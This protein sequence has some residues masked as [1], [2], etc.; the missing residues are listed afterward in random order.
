[1]SASSVS[2]TLDANATEEIKLNGNTVYS[3]A[4]AG[5]IQFS[6]TG[7]AAVLAVNLS[8]GFSVP[9]NLGYAMSA[10]FELELNTYSTPITISGITLPADQGSIQATGDLRFLG[11]VVD[12]HGTFGITVSSSSLSVNVAANVTFLGATFTADGFAGIY[13]DSNPG[14]ALKIDLALPGGAQG[15]APISALGNN[16]VISGAFELEL[17][18]CSVARQN[19]AP[20]HS[21]Y[22]DSGFQVAVNNLGVYLYGFNLTGS[23]DISITTAG[24]GFDANLNLNLFGFA[25]IGISGYYHPDQ[26]FSFTGT[27]GFQFGDHTFGFGG[28]V[29][30]TVAS[31]GFDASV[32]GWAAAF[33]L[34]IS[35]SGSI[36]ITGTSV[37]ISAAFSVTIVPAINIDTPDVHLGFLGTIHG[38]HIHTAA[39]VITE[40]ATYHLGS[41]SPPPIVAQAAP[42]PPTPPPVAGI[43]T[44]H[45]HQNANALELYI[46]QDVGNRV[47]GAGNPTGPQTAENYSISRVPGDPNSNNGETVTVSALGYIQTFTNVQ[48]ILVNNTLTGNDTINVAS[49]IQVP[50]YMSLGSGNNTVNTGGGSATVSVNGNGS[51][52]ITT[53]SG[54]TITV[55][56]GGGG[57]NQISAGAHA[58]VTISGNGKNTVTLSDGAGGSDAASVTINGTGQNTINVNDGTPTISIA[59]SASG[60]NTIQVDTASVS[61][62]NVHGSGGNTIADIGSGAATITVD[63]NGANQITGGGT[64]GGT[65][66]NIY[67]TGSGNNNI[68]TGSGFA[69]IYDQGI[70][71]NTVSGGSGGGTDYYG[72][73]GNGVVYA[74][75]GGSSLSTTY[76]NFNVVVNGYSTY[77]LSNYGLA[78]GGYSLG[79][80]GVRNVT[81]NAFSAATA[82]SFTLAN[83]TGNA[84]L[85]GLGSNNSLT[86]V[87]GSTASGTTDLLTNTSLQVTGG[88]TQTITLADFQTANLVGSMNGASSFDLTSWTGNGS[89]TGQSNSNTLLATNDVASF[90]LSDTLFQRSGHGDMTLSQVQTANLNGGGSANTFTVGSWSGTANLDGKNGSDAYNLTLSG[91][92]TGT[93]NVSDSGSSGIDTL[94]I[95]AQKT[96]LVTSTSVR[97]GTQRVN[98]G[99]SGIEVLN[100]LGGK[101]SLIFNDQST[102]ANLTT[103]VQTTGNSN[104]INIGST[105]GMAPLSPGVVNQILGLLNLVGSGLDTANVDDT[106]DG[107]GQTGYLTSTHLT[108]LA[109]GAQGIT[110]SGLASLNINLGTGADTFDVQATATGTATTVN[111][112]TGNNTLNVSS[113]APTNTGNLA[114][115]KSLLT[116]IGGGVSTA[117]ISDASDASNSSF[118]LTGTTLTSSLNGFGSGGS[119]LYGSLAKVNLQ[120]GSKQNSITVAGNGATV[121]T[122]ISTNNTLIGSDTVNVSSTTNPLV[123]NDATPN[124]TNNVQAIGTVVTINGK[125]GG[126]DV[127]NVS[128]NAPTNTGNLAGIKALLTINGGGSSTANISDGSD[129]SNSSFN[130]TGTTL[131]SSL[132]GFGSGGSVLYGSLANLNIQLGSIQNAITVTGNGATVLT[133]INT[134]STS[135][136]SDTVNVSSTTNPLVVNDT[137]T[138][139]INNVQS[140]NAVVTINGKSGGADVIS[141]SSNAP[142]N[143]G[144][145]AGIKAVLTI[146]GGGGTSTANVSDTGDS[147][148]TNSVLSNSAFISTAFGSGG[149]IN[150]GTLANLNIKLGS[151]GNQFTIT[152][153]AFATTTFVNTGSGADTVN[154]NATT[155]P[156]TVNTGGGANTNIVN[157]GSKQPLTNGIVDGIQGSLTIVGDGVDTMNVD[158]TGSSIAK[159]GTLTATTLTGLNMGVGGI[160]YSGLSL[161]NLS[162]GSGGSSGNALHINVLSGQNLPAIANLNGGSGGRDILAANWVTD[163]NNT[164]NLSS[165]AG[166]AVTIGNNFNGLMTDK[167]PGTITSIAI[168]GSLTASGVLTVVNTTDTVN[169]TM[170]AGLL[171]DIGTMTIGGSI[172]GLVQVTGDITTLDVGPANTPTT[173]GVNDVTGKVLVAG[174]LTTASISGNVSGLIQ[175]TLTTNSLYIGGSLTQTGVLSAVNIVD[176]AIGDINTLTIGQDFAG[177][178]TVSGTLGTLTIGGSFTNTA[179][180]TVANLNNMTVQGDLAGALAVSSTLKML[181]VHGGTPGTVTAGQIGTIAVYA[182]YGPEVAQIMEAGIQRHIEAA[183][184]SVPFPIPVPPP[185]PTTATSPP[186][187]TFQYFYE[188]LDS[189]VVEG[190]SSSSNLAN[191][192]LTSRVANVSGS[193]SP[194]QFDFSLVTYSDTAKFNLA[195]LDALGNSGVSGIRNVSVEGDMLVQVTTTAK[196][197]FTSDS[198]PAGVYLPK[199]NLA[200]VAVRNFVPMQSITVRSIQALAVGSLAHN[201]GQLE[202]GSA[203]NSSEIMGLLAPGSAIVQAGS[204]NGT[205][206]ETYKVPFSDIVSQQVGFFLALNQGGNQFDSNGIT[207]VVQ[208]MAAANSSGSGNIVTQSNAARGAV[209]ALITVAETFD[210]GGNPRN[211][212]IESINLRGD[213]GSIQTQQ[214]FGLMN[215]SHT[216]QPFTLAITSTGPLGDVLL[217]GSL[218]S[219]TA[220]S[221]FGSLPTN[222]AFPATTIIQTTGLRSDPITSAITQV[223][224]DL[225]RVYVTTINGNTTVTTTTIQANGSGFAGQIYCGGNLISQIVSNGSATGVLV[226]DPVAWEPGAGNLGTTFT[227]PSGR[228]VALGGFISN[229]PMACAGHLCQYWRNH[230][231]QWYGPRWVDNGLRF[232]HCQRRDQRSDDRTDDLGLEWRRDQYQWHD[233]RRINHDLW[234]RPRQ[235]PTQRACKPADDCSREWLDSQRQRHNPGRLHHHLRLRHR[236]HLH[237][238]TDRRAGHL[239]QQHWLGLHHQRQRRS[240]RFHHYVW[241]GHG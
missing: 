159:I 88:V 177:T 40:Y 30:I 138:N 188:G 135:T 80:S 12:L 120:L 98:Y 186:G 182:G 107:T 145:L 42:P 56:I 82:N 239:G 212:V 116:L 27:A 18:T 92:G 22:I 39:V 202:S 93:V 101:G 232:D 137:A 156:T 207:L 144:N 15:I 91:T 89:L 14:L 7:V 13:Y 151:G 35:A 213:G 127:I 195:R 47:D 32:S 4:V 230:K 218:P 223:A 146:N 225:G 187:I 109:M 75:K 180:L 115:I 216:V 67:L 3:F 149:S 122:T 237:W 48:E 209:I 112:G 201:N 226:I 189:S 60:S 183:V 220:P 197:F 11:N 68:S 181:T 241:L 70:G 143:T 64:A 108:G 84:T 130:L 37:D 41:I 36:D 221:I 99:T 5:G 155:G 224:A 50:V 113:N 103:T 21:E 165:F 172:A 235:Y 44:D 74:S 83:W 150:Y 229:G 104:V 200:A 71:G 206:M 148:S 63:G 57:T 199:D 134:N 126:A 34:Q 26:T 62:I 102:N 17:N 222:V 95:T 154:V 121:L 33:G 38:I 16:F 203:A 58:N 153:T 81:L 69:N 105:S 158:D 6:N 176:P 227:Y 59:S 73:Y 205:T 8:S 45:N 23:V 124:D 72:E 162:L 119:I 211:S 163:F 210:Q 240:R 77:Q 196:A 208:N 233:P 178:G 55:A 54:S 185:N 125:S 152:N 76:G 194:D 46:G 110:Y 171:G 2:F 10:T 28:S 31:S 217:Q 168:G 97:V 100:V 170:R 174:Q 106:G 191:P 166:T 94:N 184:P 214:Q 192:Q 198:A 78:A 236:K 234:L 49:G 43:I 179:V 141:V 19:T 90:V 164:L 79:L 133:T 238:R 193:T 173:G 51:N 1:M 86:N 123:V 118:N 128:S 136:G 147:A 53:G 215:D 9:S 190:H 157:I 87:P 52:Q 111:S 24:F 25:N 114:G 219:I 204:S 160:T 117:N 65:A 29:S 66:T 231:Y 131:T 169:P 175:E 96:T 61:I 161:L 228:V 140:I 129:A 132:N 167:N 142:A 139:D 20:G 85:Y